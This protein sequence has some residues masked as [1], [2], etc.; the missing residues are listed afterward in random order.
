MCVNKTTGDVFELLIPQ[1]KVY[2]QE[3]VDQCIQILLYSAK[4]KK[5]KKKKNVLVFL[6]FRSSVFLFGVNIYTDERYNTV[7]I[8]IFVSLVLY[9][10]KSSSNKYVYSLLWKVKMIQKSKRLKN[11]DSDYCS[12]C[13][14]ALF[15]TLTHGDWLSP[16]V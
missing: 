7:T 11:L 2:M 14:E 3:I 16:L 6:R 9:L 10:L 8:S 4:K 15:C 1:Y 5:K 12:S 13:L